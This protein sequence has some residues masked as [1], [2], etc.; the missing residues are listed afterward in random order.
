[1][2]SQKNY[3]KKRITTRGALNMYGVFTVISLIL[4]IY[5][6]PFSVN[7]NMEIFFNREIMLSPSEIKGFLIFIFISA[8]I[9][10]LTISIYSS[11]N[12]RH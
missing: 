8:T 7:D 5:T 1:M 2:E 3:E 11:K 9:Y 6:Q 12:K 4:S 10:F